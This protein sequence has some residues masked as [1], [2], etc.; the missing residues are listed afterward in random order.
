M[1]NLGNLVRF[2]TAVFFEGLE[3]IGRHDVGA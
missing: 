3:V 2:G 1:L